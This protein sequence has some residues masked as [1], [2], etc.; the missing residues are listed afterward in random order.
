MSAQ[1]DALIFAVPPELED[2]TPSDG[3]ISLMTS[4]HEIC[5]SSFGTGM[6][7][8]TGKGARRCRCRSRGA[9]AKLIEAALIPCRYCECSLS[10][11]HP[12]SNSGSHLCAF[13]YAYRRNWPQVSG[14][15]PNG[16]SAGN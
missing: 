2:L 3:S 5:L 15:R 10:N 4:D 1:P 8:I 13:N 6:E 14:S 11:Y 12:A 9:Q 7:V 16:A